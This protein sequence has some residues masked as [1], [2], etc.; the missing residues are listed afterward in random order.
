[1]TQLFVVRHGE[2][3]W[4][5]EKRMQGQT[6]TV[7]SET[8]R[9]QAA[10]LGRR[11]SSMAFAALYSSDLLRAWDTAQAIAAQTGWKIAAD[12]RLRERRFGIFEGLTHD[13]IDERYPHELTRF[14]SRDPDY[15][16]PGGESA[17]AFHARCLPCLQE[18]AERHRGGEAVVVT[19]GLV[20]DALYRAAH[21]MTLGEPRTVPLLNASVN[22]FRYGGGAWRLE[23]WGDVSHLAAESVTRHQGSAG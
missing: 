7:L 5:R 11:L 22:V 12:S 16:V 13:E 20:L 6:D 23:T 8:G 15:V 10:A 17:H 4:N 21:G 19:H 3:L 1:M 18:I 2:T 14:Q 9:Q